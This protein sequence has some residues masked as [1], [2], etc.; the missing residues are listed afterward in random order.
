[1]YNMLFGVNKLFP[2]LLKSL[3][4]SYHGE[5]LQID[6]DYSLGRVRD[7]YLSE[8]GSKILLYTRNGGGN[9]ECWNCSERA[10]I[11]RVNPEWTS[12]EDTVEVDGVT[13]TRKDSPSAF[14]E[15]MVFTNWHLTTHPLYIR[16]YDDDFDCTYAYFEFKVP[17]VLDS[18]L[19]KIMKEQGGPP[20]NVTE[21]FNEIMKEMQDMPKEEFEKDPRF[22]P[23]AKILRSIV[24]KEA[25][26]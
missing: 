9:R 10:G 16:D 4:L 23:L 13:Y 20:Q 24:E 7:I 19:D 1:M 6:G 5:K 15:C 17:E 14:H 21:K 2:V 18:V 3:N 11:N 8:D 22:A 12:L 26:S 25:S